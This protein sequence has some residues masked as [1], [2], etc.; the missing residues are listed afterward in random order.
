MWMYLYAG[1]G[2]GNPESQVRD[3]ALR[4]AVSV[5]TFVSYGIIYFVPNLLG[6]RRSRMLTVGL[7]GFAIA[8]ETT[9]GQC[10]QG[11]GQAPFAVEVLFQ[12]TKGLALG[13][14]YTQMGVFLFKV[15]GRKAAIALTIAMTLGALASWLFS[16]LDPTVRSWLLNGSLVLAL[17]LF[18]KMPVERERRANAR[19]MFRQYP[20]MPSLYVELAALSFVYGLL[21]TTISFVLGST[22]T[23]GLPLGIVYIIPAIVLFIAVLVLDRRIDFFSLRW[24]ILPLV[25]ISLIPILITDVFVGTLC[26]CLAMV[27]FQSLEASTSLSLAEISREQSLP[28]ISLF[29]L[30]RMVGTLGMFSGRIAAIM[31]SPELT[32]DISE[33][34][35]YL[36]CFLVIA[37]IV[38]RTLAE[39]MER[40]SAS[41]NMHGERNADT[42]AEQEG[43]WARRIEEVATRYGLSK[44]ER[45][46]FEM[47]ARG[48]N[49]KHIGEKLYV[50]EHT[51]RSHIYRIYQK[52]DV[53]SQQELLDAIERK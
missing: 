49:A 39:W 53:H 35:K 25:S 4:V 47:L 3:M 19:T 46:V 37:L 20:E 38:W 51:V 30:L 15:S 26:M 43:R 23:A 1:L 21:V 29:A 10:F 28:P 45:E 6:G 14:I 7:T 41:G 31:L 50:S 9:L 2:V 24:I 27:L 22:H 48:R 34:F 13:I 11:F 32:M 36:V 12:L 44:R 8:A 42:T 52:M 33:S 18:L 16:Y 17:L 5:G 40:R